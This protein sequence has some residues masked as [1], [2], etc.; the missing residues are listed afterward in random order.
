MPRYTS[1]TASLTSRTASAV[2]LWNGATP[3]RRTGPAPRPQLTLYEYEASPWCR[4]VRETLCILDLEA[5][6]RP[7]PRETMRVEGAYSAAAIFKP[8]VRP[9]G[10]RLLFP[11][12]VD[13]TA[14][15]ALNQSA[16]IVEH[17]WSAY[18]A[19]IEERPKLD[20]W[21]NGRPALDVEQ[22]VRRH[23]SS[24]QAQRSTPRHGTT[25]LTWLWPPPQ[26][27]EPS[28]LP[29]LLD[30]ALLAAPSGLRPWPHSGLLMAPA[31][32]HA[33]RGHRAACCQLPWRILRSVASIPLRPA[34]WR[35]ETRAP[36]CAAWMRTRA[37]QPA[38]A[39][40]AVHAA[41]AVPAHTAAGG[42]AAAPP[43]G[44]EHGLGQLRRSAGSRVLAGRV[45]G[46]AAAAARGDLRAHSG[47]QPGRGAPL[48]VLG[49]LL[50]CGR[51]G[52]TLKLLSDLGS[53]KRFRI[54]EIF[55]DAGHGLS[56]PHSLSAL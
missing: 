20:R 17:L 47:A 16:T 32:R 1:R 44:P 11:F 25:L 51:R 39:R 10:G 9:A 7:C 19:D 55:E 54:L 13:H 35:Q 30:F 23:R 49:R 8:E 41:A 21:L 36:P 33:R 5:D 46:G 34:L 14:G 52:P 24:N 40:D 26:A 3:A 27:L 29:K 4:R 37:G 15:I 48:V 38:G 28:L 50:R 2:R 43:R 42:R 45:R 31:A 22:P 53:A 6:V 12:L 18:G 56:V